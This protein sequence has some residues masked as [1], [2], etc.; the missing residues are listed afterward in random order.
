M[1]LIEIRLSAVVPPSVKLEFPMCVTVP[2]SSVTSPCPF[3][4]TV[5]VKDPVLGSSIAIVAP[6]ANTFLFVVVK[7]MSVDVVPKSVA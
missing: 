7:S 5:A 3:A 1:Y 6:V 2:E 4:V